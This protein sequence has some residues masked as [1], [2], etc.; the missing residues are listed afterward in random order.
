VI[1]SVIFI[2]RKDAKIRK[3]AKGLLR[4]GD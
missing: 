1:D 3:V 4:I 2:S